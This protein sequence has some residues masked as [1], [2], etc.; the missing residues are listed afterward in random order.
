MASIIQLRR[1]TA[2]NWTAIDPTLAEGEIGIE[3]DTWQIKV[4]TGLEPWSAIDYFSAVGAVAWGNITGSI[5]D[6]V[7]L[8]T[9][10]GLKA[11]AASLAAIATSGDVGDLDG[12]PG[13]TAEFLRADG[14]FAAPAGGGSGDVI[15]PASAVS[16]RIAVFDGATG[17]LIKD[18]GRT[19][20]S[21]RTPAVQTV[22]SSPIV[23]PTFLDDLVKIT[24][25]TT[26]LMLANPSGTAVE[27]WGI[28]IRIKDDGTAR[29]ISY[30]TQYRA[31]GVTLPTTTVVGKTLYLAGIWNADDATLDILA[32]GQQA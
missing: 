5:S 21:L 15:G 4:G 30:D 9:E 29:A 10:L 14:T 23:T 11:D 6:Q 20:D 22:V 16:E 8:S 26:A 17:K 31:I 13:G 25:Q 12:F 3:T 2:A 1:D 19:I 18:G 27:G 28:V 24:A 7:D 32:V